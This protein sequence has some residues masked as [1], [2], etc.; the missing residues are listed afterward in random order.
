MQTTIG[1]REDARAEAS[2]VCDAKDADKPK[3]QE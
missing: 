3:E 2:M 1:T